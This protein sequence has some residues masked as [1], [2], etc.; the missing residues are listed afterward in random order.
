M[1]FKELELIIKI[2][3]IREKEKMRDVEKN[4]WSEEELLILK[5]S[6]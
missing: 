5:Y 6:R 3:R 2:N 4:L 1:C